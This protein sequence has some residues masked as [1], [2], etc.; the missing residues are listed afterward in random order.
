MT[1][2]RKLAL[3]CVGALEIVAVGL[4]L[5]VWYLLQGI[6]RVVNGRDA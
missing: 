1:R 5:M 6:R 4:S 3:G 2:L